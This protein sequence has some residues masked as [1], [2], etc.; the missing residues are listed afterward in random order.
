MKVRFQA[1]ADLNQVILLARVRREPLIDFQTATVAGLSGV[2]DP[3]IL[4]RAAT[5]GRVLV[6]H[7]RRTM[8]RHFFAA[9]SGGEVSA[10]LLVIPQSLGIA[11]AVDDLILIWVVTEAE[12]W[13]NRI[14][15]LP[16]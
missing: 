16:P 2:D 5:D 12:E 10:R 15:I 6:T 1:D 9:F 13:L 14:T 3:M 11:A 8:P 7:D 4:A